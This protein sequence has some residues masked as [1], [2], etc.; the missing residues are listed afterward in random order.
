MS[1]F[2]QRYDKLNE[3]QKQAVD[4]IDGPVMVIAGPGS[5]KTEL[6]GL[7]IANILR[8][9]DA[10]PE[11]IL[12][13]TFTE[14]A[15]KN[16]RERLAGLIGK[17]A[18]KV[19]IHTF[20]SFGSEI[21]NRHPECFYE[22]AIYAPIDEITK[23]EI[24]EDIIKNLKWN[25]RLK[26]YHPE[27]GYTYLR[28]VIARID[29]IKKGGLSPEEFELLILENKNFEDEAN[30]LISKVFA[31]RISF[32]M[33]A[34]LEQLAADLAAIPIARR[35]SPLSDYH[36]LKAV[37]LDDLGQ[38]VSKAEETE[39]KKSKTKPITKWKKNYLKKNAAGKWLLGSSFHS[40]ELLDLA[41]IYGEYQDRIH[42]EGFYDFAD[43]ILDTV[44]ELEKNPE[45][46]YE[47]QEK[48]LYTLVDE[49]QD[50][51]GAQMRLL[52]A[53]LNTEVNEGR[54]NVLAVGDDDQSIY[55]FQGASLQNF[56]E[57][58][59]KYR[60]VKKIVLTHNYRSTQEI[61][62]YSKSV[63]ERADD[64]LV[65]KDGSIVKD[66]IAARMKSGGGDIAQREF[67]TKIEEYIF[68]AEEIKRLRAEDS[69][70]EIAV[71]ARKH[72]DLEE[73]A[74]L[75]N[76]YALPVAYER[77]KNILQEKHIR[78][79]ATLA[80][81][82]NSLD[83][84]GAEEA[85]EYLPDILAFPFWELDRIDIWKIATESHRHW[86][87]NWLEVMLE[88]GG[89]PKLI[90]E[91]L[92]ALGAEAKRRTM[93]EILDFITGTDKIDGVEYVSGFK[94]YYFSKEKFNE[95]RLAYLEYLFDLQTLFG[96][97]REYRSRETLYLKDLVD[98]LDL[99]ETHK[100]SIYKSHRLSK[101]K[102]AVSLLTAHKAKG[103][104]FDAVFIVNCN[105]N[106]WMKDRNGGKLSLPKNIPLSAEK[107]DVDD[108]I[109]LF[110]VAVTRAKCKL[111]LTNYCADEGERRNYDRLRFLDPDI[112]T[113][114]IEAITTENIRSAEEIIT[115]KEEIRH[116]GVKNIDEEELLKSLLEDYR[117]SVT[118]LNNFLN[119]TKGGPANFL[120]SNLLHFP[121]AKSPASSYGTAI[122]ESFREFY[123]RFKEKGRPP[124]LSELQNIFEE[125]LGFQGLNKK[126]FAE[127]AEKGK[128]ELESY[129][130]KNANAFDAKDLAETDFKS[131]GVVVGECPVTGKI[132]R[133]AWEDEKAK[134]CKVY[135]YKTGK[136][137]G[138][139]APGD[140]YLKIKAY[141]YKNQLIFYKILIENSRSFHLCEV[142]GGGIDFI[143][144]LDGEPFCLDLEIKSEDVARLRGL[145]EIIFGKIMRLDFP[146]IEKYPQNFKGVQE[147][148]ED[149]LSGKI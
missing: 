98:F 90:A 145:I 27:Q 104:E 45:L 127:K 42:R 89:R 81:F 52:D 9:T 143:S 119:V 117:L 95:D 12:C 49:F 125:K 17:D 75:F 100:L 140:D 59:G 144:A 111:Y 53:V 137:F 3:R 24:I 40:K 87:K 118:H 41:K 22:G 56:S 16:M 61:L 88:Y 58:L 148:E 30:K 39:E 115:F 85:D 63:I 80:R 131:E 64:R 44:Q 110:F 62:N 67:L 83:S 73:L 77:N 132:D 142:S 25:S 114:E 122:H 78:E 69:G 38:A 2:K 94:E 33:L 108:K 14:A 129:Y 128:D 51:S 34:D 15:A 113:S 102:D 112:A 21:I 134:I 103:L 31:A 50:T 5:G 57:F 136:P 35:A 6:L 66:L 4:A 26:S 7:R 74:V 139:W 36:P 92:I 126:D 37:L 91:F 65:K 43:M 11:D 28:D 55:K 13:L 68:I 121:G 32:N 60:E 135:D 72:G 97:L 146:N 46:R 107:D 133:I 124:E 10:D 48:Y 76:Y 86:D 54:P 19:A 79:I 105:E 138:S 47:L 96:K 116:Y 93:E 120:E 147:F 109:R 123:K 84:K 82:V 71:I 149:L 106:A 18:Y 1:N 29:D 99:H 70:R 141:E 130:Q 20:H 8:L 23:T 101:G